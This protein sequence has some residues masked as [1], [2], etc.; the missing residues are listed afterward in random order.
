MEIREHLK[1]IE[2]SFSWSF[3]GFVLAIFVI[4]YQEF[5]DNNSPDLDYVIT[6]NA[7]VLDVNENLSSLDILYEGESLKKAGKSLKII[8][9]KVVNTGGEA[10]LK[11]SYD[12]NDPAGFYIKDGTLAETPQLLEASN[13]YLTKNALAL[14]ESS[15]KILFPQLI[16]EPE[17]YFHVKILV[18]HDANKNPMIVARGKIA[19]IDE[20][21]ILNEYSVVNDSI[22]QR[23]FIGDTKTQIVR[24]LFYGTFGIFLFIMAI[25]LIVIKDDINDK[26]ARKNK[27]IKIKEK[28]RNNLK[29]NSQYIFDNYVKWGEPWIYLIYSILSNS[30]LEHR[31]TVEPEK[32]EEELKD[33]KK[34]KVSIVKEL[35]DNDIIINQDGKLKADPE[36]L[37]IMQKLLPL[38]ALDEKEEDGAMEQ[39]SR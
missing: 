9:I 6:S 35:L 27:V 25:G 38:H 20:I 36:I 18:L 16:I 19:G 37:S 26:R 23:A 5:F 7:N 4:V 32:I 14:K 13:D 21:N 22:T 11:S 29:M 2:Q 34:K 15:S 10:I 28:N 31:V 12:S 3:G 30:N 39:Q 17:E 1:K 33:L 24:L 8:T